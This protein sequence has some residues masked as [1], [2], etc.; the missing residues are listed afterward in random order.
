[1]E[2]DQDV[3][4]EWVYA[5]ELKQ[6][7]RGQAIR[8]MEHSIG[9]LE[10]PPEYDRINKGYE[11]LSLLQSKHSGLITTAREANKKTFSAEALPVERTMADWAVVMGDS[12]FTVPASYISIDIIPTFAN[13]TKGIKSEYIEIPKE[14]ANSIRETWQKAKESQIGK[15][16]RDIRGGNVRY[17]TT[18]WE[19]NW[20]FLDLIETEGNLMVFE[21]TVRGLEELIRLSNEILAKM[22]E[23]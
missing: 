18:P 11:L 3:I 4:G 21:N 15:L 10:G 12:H 9:F 16:G 7:K 6:A 14:S 8:C 1:M 2:R 19:I 13:I 20:K 23:D 22:R 17:G 5:D